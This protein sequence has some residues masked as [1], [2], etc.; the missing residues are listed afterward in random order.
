MR[1]RKSNNNTVNIGNSGWKNNK[2][3]VTVDKRLR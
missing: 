3:I 1:K 2:N